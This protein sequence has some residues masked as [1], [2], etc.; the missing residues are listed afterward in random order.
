[1]RGQEPSLNR[2]SPYM[3]YKGYGAAPFAN[4][5]QKKDELRM[6]QERNWVFEREELI[7]PQH[8]Y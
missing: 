8:F 2:N 4:Y 6:K 3:S 1:M 5:Q 7:S